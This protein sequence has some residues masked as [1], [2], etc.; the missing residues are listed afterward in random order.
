MFLI[1][2]T[3]LLLSASPPELRLKAVRASCSA[4]PL[5]LSNIVRPGRYAAHRTDGPVLCDEAEGV[6]RGD[7]WLELWD[8]PRLCFFS[9]VSQKST[10][11]WA[12]NE[13][14][15]QLKTGSLNQ[16]MFEKVVINQCATVY[17]IRPQHRYK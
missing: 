13:A 14:C 10:R 5:P 16:P 4:H 15:H 2:I 3:R 12:G 9:A 1:G 11:N 6:E 17:M 7:T 8:A